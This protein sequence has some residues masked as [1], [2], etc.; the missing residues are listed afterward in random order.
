MPFLGK[1]PTAG[2][3][4]IVKDDFTA[5][6][7]TREFT[8]LPDEHDDLNMGIVSIWLLIFTIILIAPRSYLRQPDLI[9]GS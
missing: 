8:N 3:S 9:E 1:Q 6:G 7:S 4:S 5:D 2:F